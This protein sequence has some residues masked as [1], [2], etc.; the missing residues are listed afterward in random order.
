[1]QPL[2][3]KYIC[4]KC[5]ASYDT[6]SSFCGKCGSD[7]RR[8]SRIEH[9]AVKERRS[10]VALPR[11]EEGDDPDDSMMRRMSDHDPWLGK[12]IDG[13]YRV[14][15]LIG[16]GGMG[17]VYKVEHQRMGKIAAL[18]MLHH[19]LT[20][21]PEVVRR[22][23][24]EAEAVSRLTHHN[25]VQVFDFGN[26]Q[27][28]SYLVMEFVRG[29]DI[30]EL[31]DRDGALSFSKAAP[32]FAQTC[33]AMVEAHSMGVIHRDLKPENILV[34][35]THRG[36]DFVK[37]LDFGLAK[38]SEKKED[39]STTGQGLIVG[40]P[41]YMA[42]EQIRG[43]HCDPRTDIYAMGALMYHSLT[44]VPPFE[45]KAPVGVLTKHLTDPVVPPSERRPNLAINARVDEMVL[46]AM[47]KKPDDRYQSASDLLEE[48]ELIFTEIDEDMTHSRR[49]FPI[50][51]SNIA[52]VRSSP[53]ASAHDAVDFGL[54][55]EL[56][57]QRSDI[58]GYERSLQ[59]R[60]RVQQALLPI[61]LCCIA[62]A[63]YYGFVWRQNQPRTE[64]VEPNNE[65]DDAT[66]IAA[67]KTVTGSIGKRMGERLS[68]RDYYR[69]NRPPKSDSS[70]VVSATLRSQPNID[71]AIELRDGAGELLRRVDEA[72]MGGDEF[73][74][75]FR[76]SAPVRIL[77]LQSKIDGFPVESITDRYRLDV[78]LS[79]RSETRESEPNDTRADA[80]P[81]TVGLAIQGNL[82]SL[83]DAD[84]FR[85]DGAAGSYELSVDAEAILPVTVRIDDAPVIGS[86]KASV[87]LRDGSLIILEREPTETPINDEKSAYTIRVAAK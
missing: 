76:T 78:E 17:V 28:A 21:D 10:T 42:P 84:L 45:A 47:E 82:D 69:L 41:Y 65:L 83:K 44:G 29:V 50:S 1:M 30:G 74:R 19:E 36:R 14:S 55:D 40:T 46:R 75:R 22:F 23:K 72:G 32:L 73:I 15:E 3:P 39:S 51:G 63:G 7:M 81:I 33:A 5:G 12:V 53:G 86:L 6:E 20:S 71:M 4:W 67:G 85:F 18:K 26:Y 49:L 38:L 68:D 62:G 64:E 35:R 80:V 24:T 70:E 77:V 11:R 34:T 79:P 8:A 66:L 48:I 2:K 25:T 58:D 59:R 27:G 56:R 37:V 31:I 57:L 43:E 16:Q 61:L 87:E 52:L 60:R 54:D 13:R 9:E